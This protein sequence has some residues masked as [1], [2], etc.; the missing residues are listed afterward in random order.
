MDPTS[1]PPDPGAE[2]PPRAEPE[3]RRLRWAAAASPPDGS[4][5]VVELAPGRRVPVDRYVLAVERWAIALRRVEAGLT[6]EAVS[7]SARETLARFREIPS[8]PPSRMVEWFLR[9]LG[10]LPSRPGREGGGAPRPRTG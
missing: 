3:P 4:P 7:E 2:T 5:E 6:E 10:R 9:L 1:D 8:P